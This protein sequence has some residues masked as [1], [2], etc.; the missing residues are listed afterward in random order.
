MNECPYGIKNE[1]DIERLGDRVTIMFEHL[2]EGFEKLDKKLDQLER[3]LNGQIENLDTKI[4]HMNET[5]PDKVK[6]QVKTELHSGVYGLVKFVLITVTVAI[7]G[8][9]VRIFI[10]G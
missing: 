10:G 1:K 9:T 6:Q 4:D 3:K 2:S 5:M 8:A 7:I